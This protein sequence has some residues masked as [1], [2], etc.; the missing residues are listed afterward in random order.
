MFVLFHRNTFAIRFICLFIVN[1]STEHSLNHDSNEHLF[2]PLTWMTGGM[3][4]SDISIFYL[5]IIYYIYYILY[6][7]YITYF[8]IKV[9]ELRIKFFSEIKFQLF[10]YFQ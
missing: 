3:L 5:Y 10:I 1:I 7:L 8:L 2:S 9:I 4:D 6:I